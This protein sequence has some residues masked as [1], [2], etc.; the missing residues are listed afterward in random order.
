MDVSPNLQLTCVLRSVP[1]NAPVYK[2]DATAI[3]SYKAFVG[4]DKSKACKASETLGAN[5]TAMGKKYHDDC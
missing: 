1:L 2:T 4:D 5:V 3:D